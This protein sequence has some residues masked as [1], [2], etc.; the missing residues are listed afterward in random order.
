MYSPALAL[1]QHDDQK[2]KEYGVSLAVKMVR[3]LVD[4]GGLRGFHFCTLNLE[5]SIERV[6]ENLGWTPRHARVQNRLIAVST[7]NETYMSW[8]LIR[9]PRSRPGQPNPPHSQ[10]PN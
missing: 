10:T 5:K 9:E 3:R 1:P 7:R 4:E 6:L 8:G 2:V